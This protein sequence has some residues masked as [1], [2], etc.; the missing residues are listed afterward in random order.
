MLAG[1]SYV[2]WLAN[3]KFSYHSRTFP[4]HD[5]EPHLI[6]NFWGLH[7][8]LYLLGNPST[9][10]CWHHLWE[11]PKSNI[12]GQ[13]NRHIKWWGERKKETH[14]N[15]AIISTH[16]IPRGEDSRSRILSPLSLI[17]VVVHNEP[18]PLHHWWSI[19]AGIHAERWVLVINVGPLSY[20]KQSD[21]RWQVPKDECKLLVLEETLPPMNCPGNPDQFCT[22]IG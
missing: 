7:C 17:W 10:L 1:F 12:I 16:P 2:V 3:A 8:H 13:K 19:R 11:V 4:K 18:F 15:V 22:G 9:S 20:K 5:Y 14:D 21:I 6:F